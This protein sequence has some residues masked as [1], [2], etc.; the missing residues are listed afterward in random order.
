MVGSVPCFAFP[1]SPEAKDFRMIYQNFEGSECVLHHTSFQL[2]FAMSQSKGPFIHCIAMQLQREKER[3]APL[4][5]QT[6]SDKY[7]KY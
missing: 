4:M 6:F 5:E 3:T 7:D 1:L 2:E